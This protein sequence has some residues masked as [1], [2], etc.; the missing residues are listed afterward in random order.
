MEKKEVMLIFGDKTPP[1]PKKLW[2]APPKRFFA[3]FSKN[4]VFFVSPPSPQK[5]LNKKLFGV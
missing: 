2:K 5:K 1:F 4:T 3:V